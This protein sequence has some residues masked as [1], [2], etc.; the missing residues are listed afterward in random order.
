MIR[1]GDIFPFLPSGLYTQ[2]YAAIMVVSAIWIWRKGT[3]ETRVLVLAVLLGWIG[4]RFTSVLS[5][6]IPM[7]IT[8]VIGGLV[9]SSVKNGA[10]KLI[11]AL[12]GLKSLLYIF[13]IT[14]GIPY[15][16]VFELSTLLGICQ[17]VSLWGGHFGGKKIRDGLNRLG[18]TSSLVGRFSWRSSGY[19]VRGFGVFSHSVVQGCN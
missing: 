17:I 1:N 12:Y 13:G 18:N 2:M 4:A 8:S 6:Y 3:Y 14:T 19:F 16:I 9:A 10:G 15:W 7:L 11:S 5:S